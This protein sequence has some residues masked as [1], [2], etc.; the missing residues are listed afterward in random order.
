MN[1]LQAIEQ[2]GDNWIRSK[3][4][5]SY[6]FRMKDGIIYQICGQIETMGIGFY[7]TGIIEGEWEIVTPE[8]G[9]NERK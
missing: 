1:L 8:K 6:M 7:R 9:I 2:A 3:D 4:D 5:F